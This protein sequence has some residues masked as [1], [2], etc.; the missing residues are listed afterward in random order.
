MAAQ[1]IT[2]LVSRVCQ[3][4]SCAW[5]LGVLCVLG[6]LCLLCVFV[7]CYSACRPRGCVV[8]GHDNKFGLSEVLNL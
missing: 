8:A 4:L 1:Q 7:A 3:P 2:L 5:L 6:A